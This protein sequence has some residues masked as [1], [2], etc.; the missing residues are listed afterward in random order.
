[1]EDLSMPIFGFGVIATVA[2]LIAV[3]SIYY[4]EASRDIKM[5]EAGLQQCVVDEKVVWQK[6]CGK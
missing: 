3:P 6:E 5:A 4:N 2:A 1:M